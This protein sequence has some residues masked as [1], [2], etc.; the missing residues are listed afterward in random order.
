MPRAR[1]QLNLSYIIR[2][3]DN[4][5][6]LATPLDMHV[7]L[8]IP[9]IQHN[10]CQFLALSSAAPLARTSRTFFYPAIE[11]LWANNIVPMQHLLALLDGITLEQEESPQIRLPDDFG[12]AHWSRFNL[13]AP[14]V[15]RIVSNFSSMPNGHDADYERI[16]SIAKSRDLLP[17]LVAMEVL[18]AGGEIQSMYYL[19]LLEQLVPPSLRAL[20]IRSIDDRYLRQSYINLIRKALYKCP[21]LDLLWIASPLS[22]PPHAVFG[23]L[24]VSVYVENFA[25]HAWHITSEFLQWLAT[26]SRLKTLQLADQRSPL[27]RPWE[28]FICPPDAFTSLRS[29]TVTLSE[30]RTATRLWSTSLV[31]NLTFARIIVSRLQAIDIPDIFEFF[32]LLAQRSPNITNLSLVFMKHTS[33]FSPIL[34]PTKYLSPLSPLSLDFL[35]ING[36]RLNA[37]EA[38]V[39][40]QIAQLWPS[41]RVL[42]LRNS[43]ASLS[44][45]AV[46]SRSFPRLSHL[47]LTLAIQSPPSRDIDVPP[48]QHFSQPLTFQTS[49]AFVFRLSSSEQDDFALYL[50]RLWKNVRCVH[51]RKGKEYVKFLNRLNARVLDYSRQIVD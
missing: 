22:P 38:N 35:E 17:N 15:K 14:Y 39:F 47:S 3:V 20:K 50:A 48:T 49:L 18:A 2:S 34:L 1:L 36:A 5:L 7:A 4:S 26:M 13:Y 45:L 32:T 30:M 8:S 23:S 12:E 43:P 46:I 9:E 21:H 51:P 25:T 37:G 19:K 27:S 42:K 29:L 41:L 44:D 6:K 28:V 31:N 33:G 11:H 40:G 10:F 16:T 24:P